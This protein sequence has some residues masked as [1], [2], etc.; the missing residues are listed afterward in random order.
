MIPKTVSL[1]IPGAEIC[2]SLARS[3]RRKKTISISVSHEKGVIVRAPLRASQKEINEIVATK[4]RWI[5]KTVEETRNRKELFSKKYAN[6][7]LFKLLGHDFP[8]LINERQIKRVRPAR[9][10]DGCLVV[11]VPLGQDKDN[12]IDWIKKSLQLFFKPRARSYINRAVAEASR[13]MRLQPVAIRVKD[14]RRSWGICSDKA[15]SFNW[16][17][18]MAPAPLVEYVV[19]HELCHLKH[20]NHSPAFYDHLSTFLPDYKDRQKTLKEMAPHLDL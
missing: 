20:R 18:I 15:L 4:A 9:L 17:L 6:G 1:N 2:Y 16:R 11:A 13:H 12:H 3:S 10:T 7:E 19:V 14:L 5:Q 8:L